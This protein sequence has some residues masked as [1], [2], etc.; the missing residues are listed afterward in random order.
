M[1]DLAW[2]DSELDQFHSDHRGH[3]NMKL[4]IDFDSTNVSINDDSV[5]V[6]SFGAPK[7]KK[8]LTASKFIPT[9]PG[10]KGSLF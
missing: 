2:M 4:L 7:M 3:K 9:K 5:P 6:I 1:I 8:K 10:S